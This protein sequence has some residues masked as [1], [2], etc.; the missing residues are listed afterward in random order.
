MWA[1]HPPESSAA[2]TDALSKTV[3]GHQT[4]HFRLLT[5]HAA[6]AA[7]ATASGLVADGH[8]FAAGTVCHRSALASHARMLRACITEAQWTHTL[9]IWRE[10]VPAWMPLLPVAHA[11]RQAAALQRAWMGGGDPTLNALA[12][13]SALCPRRSAPLAKLQGLLHFG[14]IGLGTAQPAMPPPCC[15]CWLG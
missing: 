5:V 6:V 12:S 13:S 15:G 11:Q 7:A 14:G 9:S 8:K 10:D 2:G 1:L 4:Q 3:A